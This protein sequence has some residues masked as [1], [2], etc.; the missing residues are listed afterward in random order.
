MDFG[1]IL[2]LFFHDFSCFFHCLFEAVF[3]MI[4]NSFLDRS[5]NCVN[6]EIIEISL[7]LISYFALGTFRRRS[8]FRSISYQFRYHFRIDF[9]SIFMTFSVSISASIFSLIF[10]GKWLPKWTK[11]YWGGLPFSHHFRDLFR[12]SIF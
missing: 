2:S 6:P 1:S 4:F 8:L 11:T 10:N 5:L 3:L 9:S 7:V 12:R